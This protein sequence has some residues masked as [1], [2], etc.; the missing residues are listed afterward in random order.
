MLCRITWM[1]IWHWDMTTSNSSSWGGNLVNHE[2]PVSLLD[3]WGCK[4]PQLTKTL[5]VFW[6]FTQKNQWNPKK[7]ET[8]FLKKESKV[9]LVLLVQ[10]GRLWL[11]KTNKRLFGHNE[12]LEHYL[13]QG[14]TPADCRPKFNLMHHASSYYGLKT[15]FVLQWKS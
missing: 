5:W 14:P 4:R 9:K 2:C 10:N 12:D 11:W 1:N 15:A 8:C 3:I 13:G 6:W 7:S